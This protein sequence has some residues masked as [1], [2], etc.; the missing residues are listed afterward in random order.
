MKKILSLVLALAML[1]S[2]M[3]TATAEEAE[4]YRFE[5]PITLKVSV[6]D[7]GNAGGTAPDDNYYTKWIQENFGDPRNITIEWVVIPRSEEEAKLNQLLA[8]GAETAPDLCFTYN[9]NLT[10]SYVEQGGLLELT[11]LLNEYGPNIKKLL[12]ENVIN[13]GRKNG[14]LYAICARRVN[15]ADQGVFIRKDWVEKA[16]LA[17]PTTKAELLDV[18]RYFRDN[19]MDGDGDPTNEIPWAFSSDLRVGSSAIFSLSFL[20]DVSDRTMACSPR[21]MIDGYKDYALFLNQMYHEGLMSPDF[22]LDKTEVYFNDLTS[23]RAG[24][25][26]SNWDHPIRVS[27]GILAALQTYLPEAELA[28]LECFESA[29]DPTKYYH[30]MYGAHGLNNFIPVYSK[31]PEAA[32][33]YLDW[34]CRPEVIFALQN[35]VEG[36]TYDLNEDGVPVVKNP[37]EANHDKT[38]NS[39]QNLDYTLLINGQYLADESLL[40]KAQALSYQG[41]ADE[42]EALYK[43][44]HKD[45]LNTGWTFEVVLQASSEYGTRLGEFENE[46]LTK[47]TMA[48]PAEASALFDQMLEEYKAMGGQACY[49]EATAAWDAAHP[50]Q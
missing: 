49:D 27:P 41:Y 12:G 14:G 32:M 13:A 23:G 16:G 10:G 8:G 40:I 43:A 17:M 28:P 26:Q 46:M 4:V 38:F 33:M 7:R 44:F 45:P 35:G 9:G 19:D 39:M 20:K 3:L 25:Y 29:S 31:H 18:L 2:M 37:D 30:G 6:F 24:V 47:V 21:P 1:L 34:L 36:I 15:I 48:D 22:A 11:D 42:Y 5:E 50:A